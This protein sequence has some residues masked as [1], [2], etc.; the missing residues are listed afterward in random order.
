MR[1]HALNWRR[2]NHSSH[3]YQGAEDDYDPKVSYSEGATSEAAK[4]T[5]FRPSIGSSSANKFENRYYDDLFPQLSV[6]P[7]E[8]GV[9]SREIGA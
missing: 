7:K 1:C 9:L 2:L 5:T 8:R 3:T 6:K 4:D